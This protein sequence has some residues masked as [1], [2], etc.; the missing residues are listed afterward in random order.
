MD[1]LRNNVSDILS[2][3]VRHHVHI[4]VAAMESHDD[5]NTNLELRLVEMNVKKIRE[6]ERR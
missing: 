3:R 5:I 1:N 2:R 4:G 6:M